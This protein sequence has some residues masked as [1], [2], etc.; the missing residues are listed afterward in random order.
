MLSTSMAT[1]ANGDA[2]ACSRPQ[3]L[4][5]ARSLWALGLATLHNY[6]DAAIAKDFAPKFLD[7]RSVVADRSPSSHRAGVLLCLQLCFG[8]LQ[9]VTSS[10]CV[11]AC[12]VH[13][14]C[15]LLLLGVGV[16]MK[17][18]QAIVQHACSML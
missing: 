15:Q 14:L 10:A 9:S 5:Y 11:V 1:S 4:L 8:A 13:G 17:H 18:R 6:H 7:V 2:C 3:S 12:V 16:E